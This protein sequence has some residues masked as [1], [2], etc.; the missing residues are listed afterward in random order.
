MLYKED[1]EDLI[2]IAETIKI[3]AEMD[4]KDKVLQ[5]IKE[6]REQLDEIEKEFI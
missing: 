5:S 1:F 4:T 6:M 2:T 3:Y